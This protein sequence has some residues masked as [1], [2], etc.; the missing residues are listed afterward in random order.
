[1]KAARGN[2]V[3]TGIAFGDPDGLIHQLLLADPG[4]VAAENEDRLFKHLRVGTV[5]DNDPPGN[6]FYQNHALL[7]LP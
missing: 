7:V 1:M 3:S 2:A 4:A 6:T 5:H